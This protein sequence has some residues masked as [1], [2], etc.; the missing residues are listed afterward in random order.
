LQVHPDDQQAG[1]LEGPGQFGKTE[2]WHVLQAEPGARLIGGLKS[3]LDQPALEAAVRSGTILD[4]A[5]YLEVSPG[6]T[7]FMPPGTVHALG[8]GLLIYE[9]QE[10]SDLTYRVWDWDRPQTGGRLLHIEKSLAVIDPATQPRLQPLPEIADGQPVELTRCPYF[11]L[12]RLEMAA[13]SIELD[14]CGE[15]FHALTV[16]AGRVEIR[17]GGEKIQLGEYQS[18]LVPAAAGR[19]SLAPVE[20]CTVLL[21]AVEPQD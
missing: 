15:S 12:E 10:T 11:T 8:P 7:V 17:S 6:D 9:I 19:Y 2:A 4:W 14:T 5:H 18:V 1:T 20:R 16:I 3:G 13:A 21:A